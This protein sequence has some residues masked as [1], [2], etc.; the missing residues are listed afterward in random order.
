MEATLNKLDSEIIVALRNLREQYSAV[1]SRACGWIGVHPEMKDTEEY[2]LIRT[3]ADYA[4]E[5]IGRC[6]MNL[7]LLGE[8]E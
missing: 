1:H 8:Q 5:G 4:D 6:N 3:V 2:S 7:R